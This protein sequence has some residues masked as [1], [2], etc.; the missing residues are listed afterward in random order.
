MK[1]LALSA[2]LLA[3]IT[4][5]AMA[6]DRVITTSTYITQ[7]VSAL[8]QEQSLVGVDT[9]SRYNE[10]LRSLPDVGYRIAL[11]TE[12]MLSLKPSMVLWSSDS[13]PT[14]VVE[15]VSNS[16][17]KSVT[18]QKPTTLEELNTLVTDVG[19]AF[20]VADKSEAL[21]QELAAKYQSLADAVKDRKDLKALFIM[22]EMGGAGSKNFAG[23]ETSATALVELLGL[24]N[25]LAKHFT[26]YKAVN[27]ETQIQ[28]GADVVFIGKRLES[29][30]QAQPIIR[31]E[32]SVLGWP[33]PVEPKCVF[34]VDINHFLVYGIHLYDDALMLN[35]QLES[36][37]KGIQ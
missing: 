28:Q 12:G 18:L 37:L 4:A 5:N 25:P 1:K 32:S 35:G 21:N 11:S 27:I 2:L 33:K 29:K 34:E 31:L 26:S 30:D 22:E 24:E 15:Q 14:N 16:G 8:G 23:G 36:C 9:T 13:G 7:V 10:H 17:I 3:G 19:T 20:N 6:E